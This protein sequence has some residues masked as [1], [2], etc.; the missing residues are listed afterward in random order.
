[1]TWPC[2]FVMAL[3]RFIFTSY[4]L[5][6]SLERHCS[7]M[8]GRMIYSFEFSINTLDG[9]A[10]SRGKDKAVHMLASVRMGSSVI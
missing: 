5:A 4:Q 1:M 8:N 3:K 7:I 10:N 9:N 2:L 6:F